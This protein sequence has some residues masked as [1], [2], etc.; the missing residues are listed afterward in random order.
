MNQTNPKNKFLKP[1]YR[2]YIGLGLTGWAVA[3]FFGLNAFLSYFFGYFVLGFLFILW[4]WTIAM[5]LDPD[6]PSPA[7]GYLLILLRYGLLGLLFYAMIALLAVNWVWF[8]IGS[9]VL[10]PSLLITALFFY[11]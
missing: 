9:L 10:L 1:F 8:V 6:H 11:N 5:V 2:I 3:A 7:L 4:D